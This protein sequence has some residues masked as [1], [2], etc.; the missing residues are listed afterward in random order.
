MINKTDPDTNTPNNSGYLYHDHDHDHQDLSGDLSGDLSTLFPGFDPDREKAVSDATYQ[1]VDPN[2][3]VRREAVIAEEA[4]IPAFKNPLLKTGAVFA[5]VGI[6]ICGSAAIFLASTGSTPKVAEK[7][8]ETKAEFENPVVASSQLK[9]QIALDKQTEMLKGEKLVPVQPTNPAGQIPATAKAE[10]KP[11]SKI[12]VKPELRPVVK[13]NP[14]ATTVA[15]PPTPIYRPTPPVARPIARNY[16]LPTPS[17]I[18]SFFPKSPSVPPK[19]AQIRKDPRSVY[20]AS[21]LKQKPVEQKPTT[22]AHPLI[23]TAIKAPAPVA[24]QSW[25]QQSSQGLFGGRGSAK[26]AATPTG[27]G[28]TPKTE[29]TS[30]YLASENE[31]YGMPGEPRKTISTGAKSIGIILTPVQIAAGDTT[32]Q[33]ITIG[34]NQPLVDRD[35]KIVIPAG[36]QVQFKVSTLNNG[37]LKATSTKAYVNDQEIVIDGAFALTTDKGTPLVA[38]S[39]QFGDDLIAKQ[40]QRSFVL[41][42]LQNVGKILTAPNTTSATTAGV[43]G[44]STSNTSTSNPNVIGAIFDGGFSPLATQQMTRSTAEI[45][46]LLNASKVWYLPVGTNVKITAIK[47]LKV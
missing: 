29:T 46:R 25:Q 1:E 10:T 40:D 22:Q 47:A 14:V 45:N 44:I 26:V 18:A 17:P 12:D 38:E 28:T 37:W 31:I 5:A 4:A 8:V 13:P 3:T 9:G 24:T 39:L 16:P 7:K 15:T 23:A 33:L 27:A 30:P 20:M 43:G 11:A 21:A 32:D 36:S 34:M 19:I 6:V 2:A 41:G 42:A 35:G